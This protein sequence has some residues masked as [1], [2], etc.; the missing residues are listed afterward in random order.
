MG[1]IVAQLGGELKSAIL[2]LVLPT[3]PKHNIVRDQDQ[4]KCPFWE[5][6]I[7]EF[8]FRSHNIELYVERLEQYFV[9]NSI[10]AD[11][12]GRHRRRAILISVIRA[13]A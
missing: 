5:T 2:S 11:D 3:A 1:E 12:N 9:P 8:D 10:L 7:E 13:K 6:D 4:M